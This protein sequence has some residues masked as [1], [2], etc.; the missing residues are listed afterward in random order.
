MERYEERIRNATDYIKSKI[1]YEPKIGIILGSGLSKIADEVE[2]RVVIQYRDIRGFPSSTVRGHKGELLCGVLEGKRVILFNGRFHFYQGYSLQEVVLPV[3]VAASLGVE[4]VIVTNASGGINPDFKPGDIM[5]ITDHINLL[6]TNP[7]IGR[8]TSNFGPIFVDMS[9]PY[10]RDI[11]EK[12]KGLA[13]K[14]KIDRLKEGVYTAVSGPSYETKAEIK[15]LA[16]IGADAV[17]MSTVPEVIVANQLEMKVLGISVIANMACGI[18]EGKLSHSEV[19]E[20]VNRSSTELI[21]L[22][23][24]IVGNVF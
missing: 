10:D 6:G 16:Q 13:V 3:R 22:V 11:I 24:E 5:L 17:G 23:R 4:L 19:L 15:Y 1:S 12:V 20:N 9:E 18:S 2:Q 14:A 21:T 8:D 7:L